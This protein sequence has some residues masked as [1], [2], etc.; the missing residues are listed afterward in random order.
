MTAPRT[1][2]KKKNPDAPPAPSETPKARERRGR[3]FVTITMAAEDRDLLFA[4]AEARTL[5]RGELVG[6][7]V[8]FFVRMKGRL[9]VPGASQR[10]RGD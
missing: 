7:A 6:E 8:R 4:E 2:R 1:T 10:R 3:P 9:S 5:S